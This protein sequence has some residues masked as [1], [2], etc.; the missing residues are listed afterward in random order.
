M[1]QGRRCRHWDSCQR[2]DFAL[3]ASGE[4][5]RPKASERQRHRVFRKEVYSADRYGRP[6]CV[7][8]GR[9]GAACTVGIDL[10]SIYNQIL[11]P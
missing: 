3:V 11:R 9:C 10:V 1:P 4:S 6:A 7:G 2:A 8:C 5:F